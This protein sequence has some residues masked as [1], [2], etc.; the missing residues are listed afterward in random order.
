MKM[1][2]RQSPSRNTKPSAGAHWAAIRARLEAARA[3]LDRAWTPDREA[4]ERILRSRARALARPAA[5]APAGDMIDVLEFSLDG[6]TYAIEPRHVREVLPLVTLVALPGVSDPVRG[7]ASVRGEILSVTD[8]RRLFG[9]PAHGLGELEFAIVLHAPSMSFAIL[10]DAIVGLRRLPRSAMRATPPT[11]GGAH[12]QY[13]LGVTGERTAVLN[14]G[15]LLAD[16]V[17]LAEVTCPGR[18][19][20]LGNPPPDYPGTK[21]ANEEG[22]T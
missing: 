2:S 18:E 7:I 22:E 16:A 1:A 19:A 12:A 20:A 17:R 14:G 3:A 21:V 6:E 8:L 13:L 11:L 9:L 15:R 10:A 5:L 4:A